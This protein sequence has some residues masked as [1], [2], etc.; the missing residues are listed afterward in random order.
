[1]RLNRQLVQSA[2][3]QEPVHRAVPLVQ[4]QHLLAIWGAVPQVGVRGNYH[5]SGQSLIL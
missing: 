4:I 1:M 2:A 5:M 3:W